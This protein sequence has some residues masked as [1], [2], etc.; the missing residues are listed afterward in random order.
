VII[1][2][3]VSQVNLYCL[4]TVG[5]SD[6]VLLDEAAVAVYGDNDD[7]YPDTIALFRS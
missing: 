4:S 1:E 3:S 7:V 5:T 2:G 6:M